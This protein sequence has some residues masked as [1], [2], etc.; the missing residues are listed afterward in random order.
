MHRRGLYDPIEKEPVLRFGLS[1]IFCI[2]FLL[3][4]LIRVFKKGGGDE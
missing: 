1:L 4:D 2:Y 3:K